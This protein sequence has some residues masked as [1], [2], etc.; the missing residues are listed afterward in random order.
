VRPSAAEALKAAIR[1]SIPIVVALVVIGA[2]AMN[3]LKSVQGARYSATSRVFLTNTQLA[4]ALAEIQPAFQD[5]QRLA[6]NAL[7]LARAPAPYE[8]A[9]R[10]LG[11]PAKA[12][13]GAVKVGGS[14][15]SDLIAF[16]AETGNSNRS[17]RYANEVAAAYV[18]WRSDLEA[19]SIRV[20]I[21]QLERRLE[22]AGRGRA[23]L[24]QDLDRLRLLETLNS[25]DAKVIETAETARKVSPAPVRDTLLGA[26]LGFVLALLLAG[27]RE[28]F[29]TRVRSEAD[30]EEALNKPVLASIQTL[31]KGAGLVTIGR[32]ESRWGDTYALLAANVMQ[33]RSGDERPTVLAVTSAIAGEGKT[34]T[35]SN[36]AIAMALRGQRVVLA[37]FD[38]RKP[39]VARLFRIP[40]DSPGV[41]QLVDGAAELSSALWTVNLNGARPGGAALGLAGLEVDSGNGSPQGGSN[42][43]LHVVPSGGHERGARIARSPAVPALLSELGRDAD[44]VILDTPPALATVEMA[45]LSTNVD[46]VLIVVRHGRVTRRSLLTLSRQTDSWRADTIGAVITDA[47]A[48]EDEYYYYKE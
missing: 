23:A 1:R 46:A 42:G 40:L 20:A 29:N 7:Q 17:V 44:I 3:V 35:A 30:V 11:E 25:A 13:S 2:V 36:L 8:R 22:T 31:P 16:T 6:Q 14:Q 47:P 48:E 4:P 34:T 5:P 26:S 19:G 32:H 21:R 33:I 43:S 38:L 27:A 39:S 37:D 12:V 45:E 15:D 10:R 24:Q 28:A 41:V 9:A 18:A